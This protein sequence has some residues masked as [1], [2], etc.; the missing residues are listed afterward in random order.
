[1]GANACKATDSDLLSGPSLGCSCSSPYDNPDIEPTLLRGSVFTTDAQAEHAEIARLIEALARPPVDMSGLAGIAAPDGATSPAWRLPD[2]AHLATEENAKGSTRWLDMGPGLPIAAKCCQT[3]VHEGG[4]VRLPAQKSYAG[5]SILELSTADASVLPSCTADNFLELIQLGDEAPVP[6]QNSKVTGLQLCGASE[7]SGAW[8]LQQSSPGSNVVGEDAWGLGFDGFPVE[9]EPIQGIHLMALRLL[10]GTCS[11]NSQPNVDG[12]S[13]S[14][15]PMFS[16]PHNAN[17]F[18]VPSNTVSDNGS[19]KCKNGSNCVGQWSGSLLDGYGIERWPDG[20]VFVGDFCA[21]RKHGAG[22]IAWVSRSTYEGEFQEDFMHGEGLYLWSDGRGYSG[23]FTQS[24]VG[25]H[26]TMR[27]SDGC[28]Y[29]G[30]FAEGMMH[31]YGRF[32][33]P[34][35]RFY[36]GP[37]IAGR[38]HG[39]GVIRS[40]QGEERQCLWQ[41]GEF[42]RWLVDKDDDASAETPRGNW[43]VPGSA[44]RTPPGSARRSPRD[45]GGDVFRLNGLGEQL[46]VE[47]CSLGVCRA[48]GMNF[49]L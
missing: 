7:E 23:Q 48:D 1:M 33:W 25:P 39:I 44:R 41:Q 31:G 9:A 30:E 29:T 37:W 12:G 22:R 17:V 28:I 34:D 11:Q 43:D 26:G 20:S 14:A 2:A 16:E 13:T 35:S 21:G 18:S 32:Q 45:A 27:W 6:P 46:I 38:Q 24:S 36:L 42:V 5:L 3:E 19:R 40:F 10:Q 8:H 47:S 49:E 15:P 4:E